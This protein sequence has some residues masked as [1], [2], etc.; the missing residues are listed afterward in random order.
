[1]ISY[2][3]TACC[4]GLAGYLWSRTGF[5]LLLVGMGWPH[6]IFGFLFNLGRLHNGDRRNGVFLTGLVFATV[7]IGYLTS[8]RLLSG[9]VYPYFIFHAFR[10]EIAIYRQRLNGFRFQSKV[11]DRSGLGLLLGA[12]L[13]ILFGQL[14][15]R[16]AN[17]RLQVFLGLCLLS[18]LLIGWTYLGWPRR[19][20]RSR[21][22]FRYASWALLSFA[23]LVTAMK[24]LRMHGVISPSFLGFL[25]VFHYFSWYVFSFQKMR[26]APPANAMTLQATGFAEWLQPLRERSGF[27]KAVVV[28]NAISLA[29]AYAYY[30][31]HLSPAMRIAFDLKFFMYVLVFHVTTSFLPRRFKGTGALKT[32]KTALA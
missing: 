22:G 17:G 15:A 3:L 27:L 6:V 10:D 31:A 32:L 29:G 18:G 26:A 9:I 24:W 13:A 1:L 28:M 25:V 20:E 30:I 21:A 14:P 23:L 4:L 7:A 16:G 11:F 2:L 5:D 8:L 12:T 19:W